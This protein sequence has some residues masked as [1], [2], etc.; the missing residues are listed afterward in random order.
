MTHSASEADFSNAEFSK[1][2]LEKFYRDFEDNDEQRT[3]IEQRSTH[4]AWDISNED[5][6]DADLIKRVEDQIYYEHIIK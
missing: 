3:D 4:H 6:Q 2:K 5:A 1:K